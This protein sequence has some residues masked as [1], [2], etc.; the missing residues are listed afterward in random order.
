MRDGAG[1]AIDD[2]Q[3]I[4]YLGQIILFPAYFECIIVLQVFHSYY[5]G[6]DLDTPV[7][8]PCLRQAVLFLVELVQ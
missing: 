6:Q 2:L 3:Q 7:P 1:R 8:A 4:Q 5:I